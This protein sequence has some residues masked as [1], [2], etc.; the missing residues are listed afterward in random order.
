MVCAEAPI[1]GYRRDVPI[2][3]DPLGEAPHEGRKAA[4]GCV[5]DE[6]AR[7]PVTG[8]AVRVGDTGR[9]GRETARAERDRLV[10][11][12]D[13]EG[14]LTFQY[15]EGLGVP[16]DVWARHAFTTRPGAKGD[17]EAIAL[18]EDA[19]PAGVAVS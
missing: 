3:L 16:V 13:L 7:L 17:A 12:T 11:G 19:A 2:D 1:R 14:E 5:D 9:H 4:V 8:G 6:P 18:Y 10:F 15:V